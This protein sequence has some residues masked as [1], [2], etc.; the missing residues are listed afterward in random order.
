MVVG[1]SKNEEMITVCEP[2]FCKDT[3]WK[4][5]K[6]RHSLAIEE[7]A[8]RQINGGLLKRVK[9]NVLQWHK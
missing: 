4:Q 7:M 6:K 2:C 9:V 3:C 1:I 5:K 8:D